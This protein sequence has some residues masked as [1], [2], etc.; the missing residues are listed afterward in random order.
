MTVTQQTV[1]LLE[2]ITAVDI[3]Q[4][5]PY[6]RI[7]RMDPTT[8]LP[9]GVPLNAFMTKPPEFGASMASKLSYADRPPVSL[10]GLSVSVGF[11]YG[12]IV[13]EDVEM[14]L[15]VHRP[16]AI[17]DDED[18]GWSSLITP[19]ESHVLEY[20]W[21]GS[22]ANDLINGVGYHDG[23]IIVPSIRAILFTTYLYT[24]KIMPTGEIEINVKGKQN[25]LFAL[26]KTLI[27]GPTPALEMGTPFLDDRQ[28]PAA[29]DTS[30]KSVQ[31]GLAQ[32]SKLK[33]KD[34][35]A[36]NSRVR[37]IDVANILLAPVIEARAP[38][39]GFDGTEL[40]IGNFNPSVGKTSEKYG[41]KRPTSIGDFEV[42]YD[43]VVKVLNTT[44]KTGKS[45]TLDSFINDVFRV[46]NRT[47][48]WESSTVVTG[49]NAERFVTPTIAARVTESRAGGR[50]ILVVTIFDKRELFQRLAREGTI[51]PKVL[52]RETVRNRV[53]GA[54]VPYVAFGKGLSFIQ[55][56]NFEVVMNDAIHRAK[57]EK[58]AKQQRSRRQLTEETSRESREG[59][60]DDFHEVWASAIQGEITMLGNFAFDAMATIW[61]DFRV[62]I[63]DGLFNI[64]GRRDELTQAGFSTTIEVISEGSDP[65]GSRRR[66]FGT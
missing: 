22:S 15:L 62:P 40:S 24:F 50:R 51:D 46:P 19:G 66:R 64:T 42:P 2:G 54:G 61:F 6:I 16:S 10:Q 41:S 52:S 9:T 27:G 34:G 13:V 29:L 14:T 21:T 30:R 58:G 35:R 57:I 1:D 32:L 55:E 3:A 36:K 4:S 44:V 63:W 48:A 5:V 18:S 11:R 17:F 25:G 56:A 23:G 38:L 28:D 60:P 39:W 8:R 45:M 7:T 47:D 49:A 65:L 43:D 31:E 59:L 37:L 33:V 12:D 20:G 26:S 53:I